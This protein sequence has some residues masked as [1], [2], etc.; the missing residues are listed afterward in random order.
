MR[1]SAFRLFV[2]LLILLFSA[3]VWCQEL[4]EYNFLRRLMEYRWSQGEV[5]IILDDRIE[6]NFYQP[7]QYN[8]KKSGIPGF[9]IRIFSDSGFD[10]KE[11]ALESRTR[12]MSKYENIEAYIQYDIPNYKVYVGDCRLRSEALR[13]LEIIKKDFPNAFI[14]MQNINIE[15]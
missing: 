1:V 8:F 13:I 6:E 15:D 3:S 9:R 12:F 4:K 14:V 11:R 10:A 7:L 5:N 2:S